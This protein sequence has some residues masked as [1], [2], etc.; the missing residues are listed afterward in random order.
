MFFK[1]ASRGVAAAMDT[2]R[3]VSEVVAPVSFSCILKLATYV[4]MYADHIS[5]PCSTYR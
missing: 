5:T 1:L 2:A 4:H 3:A